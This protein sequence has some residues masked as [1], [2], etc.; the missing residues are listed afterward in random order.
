MTV[1]ESRPHAPHEFA[2]V[3][4]VSVLCCICGATH[5]KGSPSILIRS[6]DDRW[7]CADE[8]ACFLRARVAEQAAQDA[9]QHAAEVAA[10]YRALD[11]VWASLEAGGWKL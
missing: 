9:L 1:A 11:R 6:E 7:W 4:D 8:F 3:E 10:M 5:R 2:A